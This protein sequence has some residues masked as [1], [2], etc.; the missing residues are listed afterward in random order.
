MNKKIS[1]LA[2]LAAAGLVFA[3]ACGDDDE[4]D[5]GGSGGKT[6]DDGGDGDGGKGSG[7]KSG[8]SGGKSGGSGG[9]SSSSG[10]SGGSEETD[11]GSGGSE[12]T[13]EAGPCECPEHD[14]VTEGD[15]GVCEVDG[16]SLT[17]PMTDD[18]TM[19]AGC[20]FYLDGPL[21]VGDDEEE[22]VLEVEP[23]VTVLG[24]ADSFVLIQR[25]SKI[26]AEGTAEAPI[27]FTSAQEVGERGV[28]DWGGLVINGLA[29]INNAGGST[30]CDDDA[31]PGEAA[32]GCYGGD[33]AD[34]NS[35][36]LKYVRVE[37]AGKDIDPM[38]ELN[39]IAF[40]GVGS[41][42]TVDYVQV[43]MVQDDAIEFFGGTVEVKHLYLTGM[44][45][46]GFDWTGGFSGKAQFVYIHQL[47]ESGELSSDPRGIEADN[48][49]QD[50]SAEPY[51]NPTLSNFTIVGR[52]GNTFEG[53]RLRRGTKG[54]VWNTVV[55]TYGNCIKV[56]EDQTIAN[57][58]DG[59]L[60]VKN[61]VYDCPDG[62]TPEDDPAEALLTEDANIVEEDPALI[63]DKIP[64]E[65]SPALGI[66]DGPSD[67][68]F[69]EVD[70]AGAFDG[71]EDWSEGWTET[72][73]E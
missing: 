52:D 32:T 30:D 70:F 67:S 35:G 34:D 2:L 53:I 71:E 65:D 37:F 4:G 68:F 64:G 50:N 59:S 11:G 23:G 72:A 33:V 8:G 7:G 12:P 66:G 62:T 61:H 44:N 18:L 10:G 1:L 24:G 42:T 60:V 28:Q 14:L 57:I 69:D 48:L 15:D 22:T 43:H 20:T 55:T 41:G 27:V 56:S 54:Q 5:D 3:P 17:E 46:D 63:D 49:E 73:T 29:P 19:P 31:A 45:D 13:P 58:D 6:S 39:G 47:D 26:M 9:K 16:T 38:N 51:A 21:I 40:Q 25:H 36:V